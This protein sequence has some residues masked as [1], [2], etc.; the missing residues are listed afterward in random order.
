[1]NLDDLIAQVDGTE[2]LQRL[3]SAMGVKAEVDELA[4][5]LIGHFVDQARR[6]GHSWSEI[7]AAMGVS[8]QA[9]QQRHTSERPAKR[10][11]LRGLGDGTLFTRFTPRARTSVREAND[12]AVELRHGEL[13]TEHLLLGLL[14]VSEGIAGRS[15]ASMGVTRADVA[16]KLEPGE[17]ERKRE[18][19]P[20][21]PLAKSALAGAMQEALK[22]GHNYIGTE[23]ILLAL[24]EMDD[25]LAG[26]ILGELGVTKERARADVIE[27]LNTM[28][29]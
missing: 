28:T 27:R 22:L 14:A 3:S 9:A 26:K 6:A 4:D 13:G 25:G 16:A 10:S 15:L 17:A 23:H 8:K 19:A 24:V 11:W 2:P 5:A 7:G 29:A 21:T 12:A 20:F 1:M 18:R